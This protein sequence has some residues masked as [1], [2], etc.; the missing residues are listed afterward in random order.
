M[1]GAPAGTAGFYLCDDSQ[2][3]RAFTTQDDWDFDQTPEKK[4][5]KKDDK[6]KA[7]K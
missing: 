6:A 2:V 3:V 4:P 7:K 1:R 5:E